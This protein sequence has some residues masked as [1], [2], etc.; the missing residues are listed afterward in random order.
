MVL[1][2]KSHFFVRLTFMKVLNMSNER[3]VITVKK[4]YD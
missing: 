2:F 4:W 3:V 1:F